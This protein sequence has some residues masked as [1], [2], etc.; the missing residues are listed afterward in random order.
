MLSCET[1][2]KYT[3]ECK[4]TLQWTCLHEVTAVHSVCLSDTRAWQA[5]CFI[6]AS[7]G[8]WLYVFS[9]LFHTCVTVHIHTP[10]LFPTLRPS[11]L[12][13]VLLISMS[14]IIFPE[15]REREMVVGLCFSLVSCRD[16]LH[17]LFPVPSVQRLWIKL[18][19]LSQMCEEVFC[20]IVN[21]MWLG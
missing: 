16:N 21:K 18:C 10:S 6:K 4:K 2:S 13:A 8:R 14:S 11:L 3:V 15:V 5:V 12:S 20:G 19:I 1:K 7:S 9:V 17:A